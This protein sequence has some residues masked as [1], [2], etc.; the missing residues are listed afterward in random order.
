MIYSFEPDRTFPL[1]DS[2]SEQPMILA[3]CYPLALATPELSPAVL[4]YLRMVY[5]MNQVKE[6]DN[7]SPGSVVQ[8]IVDNLRPEDFNDNFLRVTGLLT[9]YMISIPYSPNRVALPER[10]T[11]PD[12]IAWTVVSA[13]KN[14]VL[15]PDNESIS[16][17]TLLPTVTAFIRAAPHH[18]GVKMVTQRSTSYEFY[19]AVYDTVKQAYYQLWEERAQ[20][21]HQR[22]WDELTESEQG[23]IRQVIPMLIGIAAPED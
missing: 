23:A 6:M 3:R 22:S 4:R 18:G 17:D 12:S 13:L 7:L 2:L 20:Q 21:Q 19:I 9:F 11:L 15:L 1:L 10:G 16:L 14:D 8:V 5:E